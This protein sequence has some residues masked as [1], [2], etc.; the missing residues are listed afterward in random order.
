LPGEGKTTLAVNLAGLFAT[1]GSKTLLIDG[2]FG[3]PSLSRELAPGAQRGLVEALRDGHEAAIAFDPTRMVYILPLVDR[4]RLANSADLLSSPAMKN[5]LSQLATVFAT[6]IVELPALSR[7]VD[8]RAVAPML[9]QCILVTKWGGTPL[10]PLK[11]AVDLL[12]ADQIRLL[13]A[14]I[15]RAEDGIP[16]L[17]GWR[18]ADLKALDQAG[19][20]DR[21][22]QGVSRRSGS[23]SPRPAGR[24]SNWAV[25]CVT[26]RWR[27]NWR[28]WAAIFC[29]SKSIVRHCSTAS[30]SALTVCS[31]NR[32]PVTF[33]I[34]VSVAPP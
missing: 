7:T 29:G 4:E 11:E 33:G 3:D 13:G 24:R 1:S 34:T 20:I 5:L 25:I 17:F 26:K 31:L 19:Y 15:N 22:I 6:V 14:I 12:R 16:P 8:A 9:D 30:A 18:L 27:E 21:V 10:E 2:N 28:A 23:E 32:S